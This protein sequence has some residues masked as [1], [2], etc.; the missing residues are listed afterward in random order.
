VVALKEVGDDEDG[1]DVKEIIPAGAA[2][3]AGTQTR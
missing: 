1:V 3:K 2:D